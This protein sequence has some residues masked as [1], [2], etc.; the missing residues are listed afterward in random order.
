MSTEFDEHPRSLRSSA[1]IAERNSRLN[2]RS[3]APLSA[4]VHR[5]RADNPAIE[6]PYFDPADGGI[7]AD[8]LFLF[9]KPGRK[10]S[11]RGGGSGFISRNNDDPTAEATF[12]FMKKALI[13]RKRTVIWNLIPGWN[14]TRTV[15]RLE[16][17]EGISRLRELIVLLEKVRMIVLVGNRAQS[18]EKF[19]R[20][21]DLGYDRKLDIATSAHPSP[22]V[23][24][25][26]PDLWNSI[27]LRWADAMSK[28]D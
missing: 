5:L 12:N 21:L 20:K 23:R 14:R 26:H 18:A 6:F 25:R 16:I 2:E 22:L 15:T 1:A 27:P 19:I 4:Y 8:M 9:E 13:K 7:D 10:T 3:V 11:E 17:K 24:A 28:I